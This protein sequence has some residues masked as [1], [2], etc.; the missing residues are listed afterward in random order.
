[1]LA[2]PGGAGVTTDVCISGLSKRLF[3][4]YEVPLSRFYYYNFAPGEK[5]V[6]FEKVFGI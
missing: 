5:V 1:M 4:N 6:D 2:S 3:P